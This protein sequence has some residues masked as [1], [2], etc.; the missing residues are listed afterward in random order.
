MEHF[1]E[2]GAA[3][4]IGIMLFR[5]KAAA[6]VD[7]WMAELDSDPRYW[8]QNAFNDL[9][10]LGLD[11]FKKGFSTKDRL[12]K[13]YNETLVMG[14]LPVSM[15]CSGHTYF[16]QSMPEKLGVDPYVVHATYQYS[17]TSGKRNR[18][19]ERLLWEDDEAYFRHPVGYVSAQHRVSDRLLDATR[20]IKAPLDLESTRPHFRLVNQQI[21]TIRALLALATATKRALVMPKIFCGLDRWWAPHDGIIPGAGGPNLP[22]ICPL[23]HVM[24]L[25]YLNSPGTVEWKESSFLDN[26]KAEAIASRTLT[27][28]TCNEHSEQCDDGSEKAT[29]I[30]SSIVKLRAQRTDVQL[31]TALEGIAEQFD[32]IEF[33]NPAKLWKGFQDHQ[34]N[35]RFIQEYTLS[36]SMWCCVQP[37]EGMAVGHVWYDLLGGSS[38]PHSD[39]WGR[40][41]D[42]NPEW[43]PQVGP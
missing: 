40:W 27:V 43:V 18:F 32:L 38:G 24:D 12:F 8:D 42:M 15:F 20:S 3:A 7:H 5:P 29:L 26:P 19:R 34:E 41:M 2:A 14:I 33:D 10:R 9:F 16:V 25:E 13:A 31:A 11:P 17:G 37:Q 23:D 1:P 22:F 4:N 28:I 21:D 6:F 30:D 39:R 36:T 35:D